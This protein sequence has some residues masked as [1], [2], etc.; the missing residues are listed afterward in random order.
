ML[1]HRMSEE[2]R[3]EQWKSRIID[4]LLTLICA[5]LP[6]VGTSTQTPNQ[7]ESTCFIRFYFLELIQTFV[8]ASVRL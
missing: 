6:A 7:I 3:Y 2:V 4:N 1:K 8:P 5:L